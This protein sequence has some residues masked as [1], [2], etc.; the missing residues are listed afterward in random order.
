MIVAPLRTGEIRAIHFLGGPP[1]FPRE[2]ATIFPAAVA[3]R[4]AAAAGGGGRG[5]PSFRAGGVNA[6]YFTSY[7]SSV[8]VTAST[9]DIFGCAGSL[10]NNPCMCGALNRHV[11]TLTPV[12]QQDPSN[13][14]LTGPANYYSKFWHDH[15]ISKL[16]Y[17]FPY[18]DFANQSSFVS[19]SN[20]LAVY[21]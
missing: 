1:P 11:A 16:S 7:A 3:P 6:S 17:G 9:S 13:Y 19:H 5:D 10:A 18:D 2:I 8:G 15:A 4:R 12:Q 20:P 14:Y 21:G